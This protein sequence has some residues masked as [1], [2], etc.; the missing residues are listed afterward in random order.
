MASTITI[1]TQP[2]SQ[3]VNLKS[4]TEDI[5]NGATFSAL[6]TAVSS[7]GD[8]DVAVT[9][10]WQRST[11]SGSSWSNIS[12]ATS[13]SYTVVDAPVTYTGYGYRVRVSAQDATTVS[14]SSAVLTVNNQFA[15]YTTNT[16][17]GSARYQRLHAIEAV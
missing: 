11:N 14:S 15:P 9:Y 5:A 13:T 6:A 16:E 7:V 3:T 17:A 10:Q 12:S 8:G 2:Q 4:Y 1:S